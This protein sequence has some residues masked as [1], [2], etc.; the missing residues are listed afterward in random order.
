M[1]VEANEMASRM[2]KQDDI[3]DF[4]TPYNSYLTTS[5]VEE[6]AGTYNIH[7]SIIIGTLAHEGHISYSKQNRY[8]ENA[9]DL[10]KSKYKIGL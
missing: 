9:L 7:P 5:K 6:C 3:I 10:I 2:L 8:K 4:L 1:E